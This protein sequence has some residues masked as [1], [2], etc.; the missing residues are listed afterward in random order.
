MDDI[1]RILESVIQVRRKLFY[2]IRY[3]K[4]VDIV[5][6]ALISFGKLI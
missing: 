6:I 1:L 5:S 4:G 2:F 3:A